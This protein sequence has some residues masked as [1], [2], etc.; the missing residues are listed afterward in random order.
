MCA[1]GARQMDVVVDLEIIWY[2]ES[3]EYRQVLGSGG[4]EDVSMLFMVGTYMYL[5]TYVPAVG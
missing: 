5:Q 1:R 4:S 2:R 3:T